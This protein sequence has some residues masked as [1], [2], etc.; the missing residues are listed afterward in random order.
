MKKKIIVILGAGRSGRQSEKVAHV[1]GNTITQQGVYDV[2][3]VDVADYPQTHV[4]SLGQEK[5]T[6]WKQRV[7]QSYGF[8]IVAPEYNHG[9]PGELKLLLDLAYEEYNYKPFGLVG[10]S[11]GI[12]GGARMIEQLKLV[13]AAFK[14]IVLHSVIYVGTVQEQ[15]D[16]SGEFINKEV[17][18]QRI[19]TLLAEM[20]LILEKKF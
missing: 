5:S 3:L 8:I 19:D 7:A 15:F 20:T 4:G 1:I 11:S 2:D 6:E 14:G 12:F 13:I 10:V 17:W 16:A 18:A 9:Y